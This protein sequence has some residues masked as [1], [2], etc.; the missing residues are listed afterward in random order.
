M[1]FRLP[2]VT[3]IIEEAMG[4]FKDIFNGWRAMAQTV[5]ASAQHPS[6]EQQRL[7]DLSNRIRSGILFYPVVWAVIGVAMLVKHATPTKL[8]LVITIFFVEVFITHLRFRLLERGVEYA[9]FHHLRQ[10]LFVDAG[11]AL[12]ALT[13]SC[14]LL[15]SLLN[16]PFEEHYSLIITA[17]L[18]LSSGALI[19]LSIRK[20]TVG[21]FL[22]ALYAPSIVTLLLGLS[23]Q[24]SGLGLVL[25][26]YCVAMYHLTRLPRREYER[27]VLSNLKLQDQAQQL[28]ELSNNDS[29][30]GLR[31]RR[32][33]ETT[34]KQECNRASRLEYPISLLIIDIDHF[35]LVNDEY[36]HLA[37]DRCLKHVAMMIQSSLLRSQDTVARIGGEE[38]AAILPG[39]DAA[40]ACTLAESLRK[41]VHEMPF[42]QESVQRTMSVSIGCC[43]A[44]LPNEH[45]PE[46]L[47]KRADQA[48][49][50]SKS[51]GR[52]CVTCD[53]DLPA[54]PHSHPTPGTPDAP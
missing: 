41:S 52:N 46:F 51:R 20:E 12:S 17:T 29:L 38:F 9:E 4:R 10:F 36:G 25:L 43:T 6:L 37:G 7:H 34:L 39:M 30:T 19:N 28:T 3:P 11:V 45:S 13:W 1:T 42:R 14:V 18:A 49:Y 44:T 54:A 26:V 22:T 5:V 47:M 32:Y 21:L 35:K 48:L 23:E 16:T 53:A 33:F 27:A 40:A 15:T 24:P 50:A 8:T 31:N 2:G